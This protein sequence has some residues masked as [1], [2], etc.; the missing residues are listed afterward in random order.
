MNTTR[1]IGH[2]IDS[3]VVSEDLP[4]SAALKVIRINDPNYGLT[5]DEIQDRNEF[6]RWYLM[7]DFELLM[8]IP[9]QMPENDFFYT[10]CCATDSE[11]S[12]FNTHDFQKSLR[13]FDKY[14]YAMKK[15]MERIQ[16]LAIIHSVI[17]SQERRQNTYQRY[18]ALVELEFRNRLMWLVSRYQNTDIEETRFYLKQ[19]I[20]E[21]NR[22]ILECRKIWEQYAPWD[23]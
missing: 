18:E 19:K 14:A 17:S 22:R 10:D 3:W 6:I 15:I 23:F 9:E 11:Y 12:A 8:M 4:V 1:N 16:D 13:P 7:Q 20:G 21:L 2:E 5:D